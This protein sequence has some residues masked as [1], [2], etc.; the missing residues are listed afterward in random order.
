M[1]TEF[2]SAQLEAVTGGDADFE[3]EVLEEYLVSAPADVAKLAAAVRTADPAGVAAAAHALKGASATIGATGFAALAFE[4]ERGGK[5]GDL[6][7]AD[8]ALARLESEF[9]EV[10]ALLEGRLR[11]AA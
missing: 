6:S 7:C 1:A 9:A 2:D 8:S 3:R 10:L 5:S 4:L 11:R